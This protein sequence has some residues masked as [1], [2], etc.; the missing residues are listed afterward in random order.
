M[1]KRSKRRRTDGY[2]AAQNA[3][4]G[5]PNVKFVGVKTN[6]LDGVC[7]D[8][9]MHR[10]ARRDEDTRRWYVTLTKFELKEIRARHW[11]QCVGMV[12]KAEE[13]EEKKKAEDAEKI[14]EAGQGQA[15]GAKE[16]EEAEVKQMKRRAL[17]SR[18]SVDLTGSMSGP[19]ANIQV[20]EALL[21]D[22]IG[23]R[24]IEMERKV[25][26]MEK[27]MKTFLARSEKLLS[28]LEDK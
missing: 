15:A 9:I 18:E 4:A 22:M 28:K 21:E 17:S 5:Q 25:T 2:V 7:W 12:K 11:Q 26:S 23:E 20:S 27:M 13:E 19:S 8:W 24:M 1:K 14:K 6:E 3:G 16:V 10:F